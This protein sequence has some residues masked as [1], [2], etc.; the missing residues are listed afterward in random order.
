MGTAAHGTFLRGI[1]AS[2]PFWSTRPMQSERN[3]SRA[4]ALRFEGFG[5]AALGMGVRRL[6]PSTLFSAVGNSDFQVLW[7]DGERV[8]YRGERHTDSDLPGVLALLPAV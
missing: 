5:Q 2:L 8:L 1:A 4:H 7:E 6:N 3:L